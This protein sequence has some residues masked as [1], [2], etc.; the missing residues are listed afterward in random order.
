[1]MEQNSGLQ[2]AGTR[3]RSWSWQ[4]GTGSVIWQLMF[5][6]EGLV[7]GL[8][9]FPATRTSSIFC[10]DVPTG[11]TRCDAFVPA[12]GTGGEIPVG[13]GWMIGLETVWGGLLYCHSFQSGSP[14]HQGV[15]AV[16]PVGGKV[17]WG[18]PEAVFAANL[19][20]SFLV[21]RTHLFAGFP[22]REYWLIDPMTGEVIE[23]LGTGFDRPN[24]LRMSAVSEE[25]R[26]GIVLSE[27]RPT[28]EGPVESI[29][30]GRYVA[31]ARHT[32]SALTGTWSSGIRV[33]HGDCIVY[34]DVMSASSSAPL[35]NNFLVRGGMLYYIRENEELVGVTLS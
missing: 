8:K 11:M 33:I 29:E 6:G 32:P 34:E 12:A 17:V 25:E 28:A 18:R 7:A 20:N 30:S 2:G 35:F 10:I 4:G 9:R 27:V 26:Q 19:G 22:E 31:E 16:D 1:M 23:S 24:L 5:P 14:E 15:W 21:Y 3:L 13:D